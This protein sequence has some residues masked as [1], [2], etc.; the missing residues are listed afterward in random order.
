MFQLLLDCNGLSFGKKGLMANIFYVGSIDF[1]YINCP[2][3]FSLHVIMTNWFFDILCFE[4]SKAHIPLKT[5]FALA[6]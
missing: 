5:A 3:V 4:I 2:M 6:T 1:V